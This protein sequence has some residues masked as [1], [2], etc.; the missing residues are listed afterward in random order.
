MAGAPTTVRTETNGPLVTGLAVGFMSATVLFMAGR[1]YTRGVILRSIGKDDWS[2]LAATVFAVVNSVATC[3]EVKYGM[4]RHSENVT[5]AEGLEQLKFLL[6]AILHYNMGMNVVKLGF[7]FQYRRIFQNEVVQRICFWFIIYVCLWACVQATILGLACLP[8]SIIV[9]SMADT[10]IDTLPIWYF[11]SGMSMGTDI[12]IFCIPIP[13]VVKLQLPLKQRI[14]V[15]GI[16]CLGF[17]VCIIS[18]YRMFTLKAGVI[19]LDPSWENIGA[20]IWS[21]IELNVSI[22]ASTLPTLRPL[23]ARIL[24]G[25]GLS[26][27][28]NDRTTYLRY[29]SE[30]A[31]IR[32][33]ALK[34]VESRKRKTNSVSTEELAL[35]DMRPSPVGST[36]DNVAYAHAS[37]VPGK[38]F[39]HERENDES[40]IVMTTEISVNSHAR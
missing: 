14:M 10:C 7:L 37:A 40:H 5:P 16:F 18:V 33:G 6:V 28:R 15:L 2:M 26:S 25:I 24:P 20:A 1:F 27:A 21:C 3:F 35:G 11:S 4:G 17:F 32:A 30:S 9:P 22:I 19:S 8:I 34:S 39:Y 23:I 29:G 31:A 12:L 13:S 38:T 36:S